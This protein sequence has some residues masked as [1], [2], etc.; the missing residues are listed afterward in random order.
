MAIPGG[1]NAE[2]SGYTV[3]ELVDYTGAFAIAPLP[4]LLYIL[5]IMNHSRGVER[6]CLVLTRLAHPSAPPAIPPSVA[7]SAGCDSLSTEHAAGFLSTVQNQRNLE[8]PSVE[9]DINCK[10][11]H[12]CRASPLNNLRKRVNA[13]K[14]F[15]SQYLARKTLTNSR[16][17][18]AMVRATQCRTGWPSARASP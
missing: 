12:C 16:H 1:V 15:S 4:Q 8:L 18:D 5:S 7:L 13:V 14:R 9:L 10:H 6:V 11:G 3:G 2:E 17:G